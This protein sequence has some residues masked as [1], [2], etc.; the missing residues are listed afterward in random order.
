MS[1]LEVNKILASIIVALILIGLISFLADLIVNNKNEVAENAYLIEIE[2]DDLS[3]NIASTKSEILAEPI[4]MFLSNASFEKGEKIF[5]K[6][7]ACHTHKKDGENKVGPNLWNIINKPK[8]KSAGFN[9]SKELAEFGGVW[10]YEEMNQFLYK[11]KEYIKGTKMNFSGLK[12]VDDR[13]NLIL[14]LRKLSDNPAIL[15]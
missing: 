14:Y 10:T 1:G 3:N 7:S 2:E 9:Y 4:E 12:K 6:C 15:P 11:P 8:G 13:A 5:K